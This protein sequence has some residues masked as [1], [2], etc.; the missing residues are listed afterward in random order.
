[1]KNTQR[2][3]SF[4]L[5]VCLVGKS[6][7]WSL[8][9]RRSG[10]ARFSSGIIS[11]LIVCAFLGCKSEPGMPAEI[12][13][14]RTEIVKFADS[15]SLTSYRMSY[16][17]T[18]V[19]WLDVVKSMKR[20]SSC[21]VPMQH[22]DT[23]VTVH[24]LS[25][26]KVSFKYTILPFD[27]GKRFPVWAAGGVAFDTIRGGIIC[28]SIESRLYAKIL[29]RIRYTAKFHSEELIQAQ[30]FRRI[31]TRL[32]ETTNDTSEDL[33]QFDPNQIDKILERYR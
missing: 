12:H 19:V 7:A 6:P 8:G 26:H 29:D 25:G 23:N 31:P 27:S 10:L 5:G 32:I 13:L 24:G 16:L 3:I 21:M 17:D 18:N 28:Y 14:Q 2:N 4:R 1:M 30:R 15:D 20:D 33:S 22:F 9:E 11:L